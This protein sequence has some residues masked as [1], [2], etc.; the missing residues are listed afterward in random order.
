VTN[1]LDL[2]NNLTVGFQ[3]GADMGEGR[4]AAQHLA[5]MRVHHAAAD[6]LVDLEPDGVKAPKHVK[7]P[8]HQCWRYLARFMT[9]GKASG[10]HVIKQ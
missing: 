9:P 10:M 5:A 1:G 8:A 2:D 7:S 6:R 3:I 4:V